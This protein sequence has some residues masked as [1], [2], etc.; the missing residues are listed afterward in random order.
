M[1]QFAFS[2]IRLVL[3]RYRTGLLGCGVQSDISGVGETQ[4]WRDDLHDDQDNAL[5]G[6]Q[7]ISGQALRRGQR[8]RLRTGGTTSTVADLGT[9][10]RTGS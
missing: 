8:A 1:S 3:K 4:R 6:Q 10:S 2:G 5:Q 7:I 9:G